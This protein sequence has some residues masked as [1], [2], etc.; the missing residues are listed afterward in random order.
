M[1][2]RSRLSIISSAASGDP[3]VAARGARAGGFAGIVFDLAPGDLAAGYTAAGEFDLPGLSDSGRREFRRMITANDLRL[4]GLRAEVGMKGFGPS[5]DVDQTLA[6]LDAALRLC[7]E[8]AEPASS[9]LSSQGSPV[10]CLEMGPLPAPARVVAAKP[11]ITPDMAG[12]ILLPNLPDPEPADAP[13]QQTSHWTWQSQTSSSSHSTSQSSP[14]LSPPANPQSPSQSPA[15]QAFTLSVDAALADLGRR[16]DRYGVFIAMRADLASFAA[17]ERAIRSANC[18]WFGV[19]LDPVAILRDEWKPDEI[20][21]R[22]GGLIR[23]VRGRDA[24]AG[25]DRRTKPAVIGQGSTRWDELLGS[26]DESGYR[27]FITLDPIDLP[28]RAAAALAGGRFLLKVD[29]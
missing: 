13:P 26:L 2:D 8:L 22:L 27:G 6:R 20:F 25:A 1:F 18:P 21:S 11:K 19:D 23:H 3:R 29:A 15:D 5:A 12:L 4:V 7:R 24:L 10:L 17:L 16:A 14:Q 28:D 9:T